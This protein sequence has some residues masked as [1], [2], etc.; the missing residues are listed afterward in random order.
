MSDDVSADVSPQDGGFAAPDTEELL[1][2]L[3]DGVT[4]D[5]EPPEDVP[6]LPLDFQGFYIG[7]QEFF[8]AF[9]EIHLGSSQLAVELV[10]HVFLEIRAGWD[11]LL[12]EGDL[13]QQALAVLS[14]HV[15]R[16]L[17][18]DGRRPAFVI[19]TPIARAM[20]QAREKLEMITG[21]NGLYEAITELPTRQFTVIVLKYLLGYETPRIA[22]YM[23]LHE[24]TVDYHGRK[25]TERLRIQLRL[26]ATPR[27]KKGDNQ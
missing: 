7:H 15:T 16:R 6:E 17:E 24:R 8:H 9:A 27:P 11:E 5:P 14:R 13:E 1:A 22:R 23:G 4:F 18:Q 21:H 3:A 10:H 12:Q 19:N 26:P 2:L 20:N 25:G